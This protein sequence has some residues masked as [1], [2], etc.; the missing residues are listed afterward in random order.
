MYVCMYV[1][2]SYFTY[3]H[4]DMYFSCRIFISTNY[5]L[6]TVFV[7]SIYVSYIYVC[8]YVCVLYKVA[9]GL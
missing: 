6:Y 1:F 7:V 4:E 8:M 9:V 5:I 2:A 3:I